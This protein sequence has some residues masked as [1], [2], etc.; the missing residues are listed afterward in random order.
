[1]RPGY[2]RE[3]RLRHL[4]QETLSDLLLRKVKDPRVRS[5]TVTDVVVSPDLRHAH[6]Y[7]AVSRKGRR[8]QQEALEGVASALGYLRGE[9]GHELDL[10]YVPE[11]H[12]ELDRTL[13]EAERIEKLIAKLRDEEAAM[14]DGSG[15]R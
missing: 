14:T 2:G 7:I 6:V 5:V 15:D 1:M 3:R 4:I 13:D 8:A 9:L 12:V 11:L 10:R